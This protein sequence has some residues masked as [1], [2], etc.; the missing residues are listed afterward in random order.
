MSGN[1]KHPLLE[2][3][4]VRASRFSG[5]GEC[6]LEELYKS[7]SKTYQ[8]QETL[9]DRY[10]RANKMMNNEILE[11]KKFLDLILSNAA[12][13]IMGIDMEGNITFANKSALSLLG[14]RAEDVIKVNLCKL[15]YSETG[16]KLPCKKNNLSVCS[17]LR[18]GVLAR[19]EDECFKCKDGTLLPVSYTSTPI[20]NDNQEVTAAVVTFED[21]AERKKIQEELEESRETLERRVKEKTQDL[22][23]AIREIEEAKNE[24][25]TANQAKSDFLANMSHEIRTPMN[26]IIGMSN[27]MLDTPLNS[28]QRQWA[29]AIK[30]SGDTLLNIINDI[31]DISKIEAGKLTLEEINFDL[32]KMLF[33]T[34]RIYL[35]Q[36]Q[37]KGIDIITE[38]DPKLPQFVVG[39]PVRLKQIFT[40]LISNALKFTPSGHIK[41]KLKKGKS[42]KGCVN[43]ECSVKDTGIGID[44]HVQKKIFEKFSQA[45]ESTTRKYGGT[46]LG[47]AI[48]QELI[49][50]M[51][52]KLK[53]KSEMNK[54]SKFTFNVVFKQADK[55]AKTEEEENTVTLRKIGGKKQYPQYPEKRALAVDDMR[56]NIMLL[57]K[58]LG[59]FGID[60]DK[61][62]DGKEALEKI[63]EEKFDI[64]F[65]DCQMP[66]M[67]G[68]EATREVR[69]H[70]KQNGGDPVTIVA[71]T[72]D[73]MTGDR[74]KCLSHGMS[75]YINK[76]FTEEDIARVLND[77]LK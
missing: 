16:E 34:C 65:M 15:I 5:D 37:E 19:S 71:V 52:G 70:E 1:K 36:A 49:E 8:E 40:N 68:F 58:V 48:V 74:E 23:E 28:E 42:E 35:Y 69:K 45:E 33:E 66:E 63:R 55:N 22:E 50:R 7:I 2:K 27:L 64:V 46:G 39:D 73:A 43:I 11:N 41:I 53:L 60:S 21:I 76:P 30:T 67:D 26:A 31:I 10:N 61:A 24:A 6:D 77:W 29:E 38:I 25:V 17:P 18:T 4:I 9:M 13:G 14:Y 12:E 54:G 47:L 72:A 20:I 75:D 56:I 44:K 32:T 62:G 51:D 59:K 3:Q 57:Q